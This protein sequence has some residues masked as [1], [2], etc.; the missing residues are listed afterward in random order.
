MQKKLSTS[1]KDPERDNTYKLLLLLASVSAR[2]M[3]LDS[4]GASA[5]FLG[6]MRLRL[7]I[8]NVE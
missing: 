3:M 8:F 6:E 4:G 5:G 2:I 1:T 7:E